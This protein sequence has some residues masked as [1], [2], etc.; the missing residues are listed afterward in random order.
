MTLFMRKS[1]S[2]AAAIAI[3][4]MFQPIAHAQAAGT[5]PTDPQIVGIVVAANQ[6][7]IDYAKLALAKSKNK[8]IRAFAQQ[9]VT[10][11]T[12]VQKSVFDLG[13]KLKVTPADSETSKS[14]QT[15]S[16]DTTAKLKALDGHAFDKAYIANETAFHKA[17]IDAVSSVLIPNAQN[18]ELKSALEGTA[19]LFQGHLQ[20]AERVQAEMEGTTSS[21][22]HGK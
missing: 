8:E 5:P 19:P 7:D 3:A 2:F 18:Q 21:H 1:L 12:A 6:I 17:V 22:T 10:D 11:H 9:M 16:A 4:A 14:L 13:A 15:Q 20:H